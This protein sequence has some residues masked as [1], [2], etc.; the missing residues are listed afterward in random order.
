MEASACLVYSP[1]PVDL[2]GHHLHQHLSPYHKLWQPHRRIS[3]ALPDSGACR[4]RPY[5]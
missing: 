5:V 2:Q 4:C 1:F 3:S